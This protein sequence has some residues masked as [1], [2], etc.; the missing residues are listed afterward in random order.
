MTH[1]IT[2]YFPSFSSCWKHSGHVEVQYNILYLFEFIFFQ[3]TENIVLVF[4][5]KYKE[6]ANTIHSSF[7]L[8]FYVY[9]SN[10]SYCLLNVNCKKLWCISW[11]IYLFFFCCDCVT[12]PVRYIH[13]V[14]QLFNL[15]DILWLLGASLIS[16]VYAT[17]STNQ[18]LFPKTLIDT[19]TMLDQF[20]GDKPIKAE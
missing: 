4:V 1:Y 9:F 13:S 20:K 3:N 11:H 16:S 5:F 14:L 18:Q 10:L 8:L 15:F 2:A 7:S 17:S 12:W 19:N 6:C